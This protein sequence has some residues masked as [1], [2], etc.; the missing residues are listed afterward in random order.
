MPPKH[1][2]DPRTTTE[3][4]ADRGEEHGTD[5]SAPTK[6][7]LGIDPDL[8]RRVLSA[9]GETSERTAVTTALE[10]FLGRREQEEMLEAFRVL[11]WETSCDHLADEPRAGGFRWGEEL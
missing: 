11:E 3:C 9:T 4:S 1:P 7:A 5:P 6:S 10:D 2:C 8:L